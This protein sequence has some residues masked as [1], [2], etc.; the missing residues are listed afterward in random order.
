MCRCPLAAN[1]SNL[2][3]PRRI[4]TTPANCGPVM[5]L[6]DRK[7]Y[8]SLACMPRD[9]L[10]WP[11]EQDADT[12]RQT[13]TAHHTRP[14]QALRQTQ[15]AYRDALNLASR[16]AFTQGKVSNAHTRQKAIYR[17]VR[18]RCG[19]PAQLTISAMRQVGATY[20]TLWTKVKQ[21]AQ[22]RAAGWTT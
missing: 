5:T 16:Y 17:E 22:H 21:N 15:L 19:L 2:S 12:H 3:R 1:I 18:A 8:L 13:E 6:P 14:D 4:W 20:K 7:P 11:H 9:W 10:S